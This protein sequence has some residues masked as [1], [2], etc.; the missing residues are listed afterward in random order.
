MKV[1]LRLFFLGVFFLL[2]LFFPQEAIAS[3][4]I[5]IK[6]DVSYILG[7]GGDAKAIFKINIKNLRSDV[8]LKKF[9]LIFPAGF[10]IYN[11]KG[12][13][14]TGPVDLSLQETDKGFKLT[15]DLLTPAI[16][17]GSENNIQVE[18][19]QKKLVRINGN[20]WEII[21]PTVERRGEEVEYYNVMII[22]PKNLGKKLSLAKP[23]PYKITG[24]KIYWKD[25]KHKVVY[26]VLGEPQFYKVEL[27]YAV[28][29]PRFA[30]S[31]I[32]IAF[33]PDTLYQKVFVEKID[34]PPSKVKIDEDGNYLGRY[35][36]G[37]KGIQKIKFKGIIAVFSK[38]REDYKR[39]VEKEVSR[40]RAYLLRETKYWKLGEKSLVLNGKGLKT[41]DKASKIFKYVVE[42]LTYNFDK[43]NQRK[44]TRL[45][46]K[47]A[48]AFPNEAVCMEYT[49][50]FI[51][52]ARENGILAR[53]IEGFGYSQDKRFRPLSLITDVLHAW[54]EYYDEEKKVWVPVDPTWADTSGIDYFLSLDFNHIAFAIHGKNDSIPLPAGSYKLED[55]K[56][57]LVEPVSYQPREKMVISYKFGQKDIFSTKKILKG[58]KVKFYLKI[59]NKGNTFLIGRNLQIKTTG[60]NV[61]PSKI[62]IEKI[63]PY[64]ETEYDLQ[65]VASKE[66]SFKLEFFLDNQKLGEEKMEVKPAWYKYM[67]IVGQYW[68]Y[69][70]L[71]IILILVPFLLFLK[72]RKL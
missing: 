5:K 34:P 1:K 69:I 8:Y 7:R 2:F 44:V 15:I 42:T 54:P 28:K 52:L 51:A 41:Q 27:S 61:N 17:K 72:A 66:G 67:I 10:E 14:D 45:G 22:L 24:N 13:A 9:S 20:I 64:Q 59:K 71:V 11:L 43:V 53:E 4:S 33:P 63:A 29:N 65:L 36:I 35:L 31:Y 60:I 26:A 6:Y 21:L 18:F 58:T 12:S 30:P 38:P 47:K 19:F 50:L 23:L 40:Q 70:G 56:D 3:N 57:V 39:I 68:F 62:L 16:G 46:A 25:V 37:A 48:L 32:Y 55:S 49:D